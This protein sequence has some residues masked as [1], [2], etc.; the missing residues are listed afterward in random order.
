MTLYEVSKV[1]QLEDEWRAEQLAHYWEQ[2]KRKE[3][4]KASDPSVESRLAYLETEVR[5]LNEKILHTAGEAG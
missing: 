2:K 3:A 1:Q 5:K 4:N